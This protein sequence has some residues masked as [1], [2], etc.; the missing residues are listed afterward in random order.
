[1]CATKLWPRVSHF[2]V[3]NPDESILGEPICPMCGEPFIDAITKPFRHLLRCP[4]C[5]EEFEV[6]GNP[7][8]PLPEFQHPFWA[9][10]FRQGLDDPF[11]TAKIDSVMASIVIV[12][13]LI[14]LAVTILAS[15][16]L[17]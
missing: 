17:L 12:F 2:V 5:G 11:E 8:A 9:D 16:F 10:Q 7:N 6:A 4:I 14:I 15:L 3:K 13:V 1:M